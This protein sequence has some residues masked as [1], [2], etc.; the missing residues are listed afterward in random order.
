[1][2]VYVNQGLL[3]GALEG[4]GLT[5]ELRVWAFSHRLLLPSRG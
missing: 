5:G 4:I 3:E 1:M 2:V